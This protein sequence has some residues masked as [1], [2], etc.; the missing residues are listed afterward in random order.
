MAEDPMPETEVTRTLAASADAVWRLVRAFG[1]LSWVPGDPKVEIRGEGV[2][3]VRIIDRPYGQ[4]HEQLTSL[5][6]AARSLT[7]V[8]PRGNPVPVTGYEA[9]MTV[10][11]DGGKGRLTWSC[12]FEPDGVSEEEAA[13]DIE[14]RYRG[15][16]AVIEAHLTGR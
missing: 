14:R 5:D 11:D 3:Q 9:R 15:A 13:R 16:I 2:G 8:V 6:D 10:S 7:Y 1:D 4:V 12:R